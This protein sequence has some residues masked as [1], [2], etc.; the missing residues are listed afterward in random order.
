MT[1]PRSIVLLK[2]LECARVGITVDEN[3]V[4]WLDLRASDS[5]LSGI[6]V[7]ITRSDIVELIGVLSDTLRLVTKP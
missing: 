4:I 2:Q 3:D 7:L 1:R 5:T 6:E